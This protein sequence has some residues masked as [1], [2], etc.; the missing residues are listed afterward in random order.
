MP[1]LLP[2]GGRDWLHKTNKQ[3]YMKQS[4]SCLLHQKQRELVRQSTIVFGSEIDLNT[5]VIVTLE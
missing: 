2:A 3:W 5:D 1:I 4:S